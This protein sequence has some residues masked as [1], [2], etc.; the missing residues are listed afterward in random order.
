MSVGRYSFIN[1]KIRSMKADILT[2]DQWDA[3]I[4]ARDM[5]AAIRILDTSGYSEL[6][7]EFGDQTTPQEVERALQEDFNRVFDEI[8]ADI[9]K[10]AQSLMTWIARK[11]QKDVIKTLLRLYTTESDQATAERLLLPVAPFKMEALLTLLEAK[12]LSDLVSLLPDQ[13]FRQKLEDLLPLYSDTGELVILEHALDALILEGL[14]K[15]VQKLKGLDKEVTSQLVGVEIDQ[16]NFMITLRSHFLGLTPAKTEEL[17]LNVEYRL[18]LDLC[19][20]A[21][22][23]RSFEE[24]IRKLQEGYYKDLITQSW[25]AY[26]Q[27]KNLVVFERAFHKY[28][29]A[30]S[31]HAMLGYPFHFGVI[32]GY[33]NL[34]WYETLNLKAVMH[35]KADNLDSN[36]IRRALIL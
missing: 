14:Y 4:G 23:A 18:P 11:F 15:K 19:R 2:S 1:A 28:I 8:S 7:K 36:I 3:L 21:L 22:Q 20:A 6:V 33:L 16:I 10:S 34:K 17:L 5:V 12:N 13:Y 30:D 25:E 26:E 31:I 9:P 32:L 24:R 35:G 27:F 29:R